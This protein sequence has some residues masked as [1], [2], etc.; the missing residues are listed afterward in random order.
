MTP[1]DKPTKVG[2]LLPCPFCGGDAQLS[3]GECGIRGMP[4]NWRNPRCTRCGCD[5]GY[6]HH[7]DAAERWNRRAYAQANVQALEARLVAL[8]KDAARY[9]W[10]QRNWQFDAH[11]DI[12]IETDVDGLD[13]TDK[14]GAAIDAALLESKP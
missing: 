3:D 11:A 8:E 10:L 6:S 9:Q 12:R 7:I 5:L 14:L 13:D 4:M 1:T 2:G